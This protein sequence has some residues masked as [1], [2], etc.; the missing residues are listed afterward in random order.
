MFR[1]EKQKELG[2]KS[3]IPVIEPLANHRDHEIAEDARR[4][5]ARLQ[6]K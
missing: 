3:I 5:I 6:E 4:A 2:D 1:P